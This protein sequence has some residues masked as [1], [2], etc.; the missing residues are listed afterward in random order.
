MKFPRLD[1]DDFPPSTWVQT[2]TGKV[3][4]VIKF[5]GLQSKRDDFERCVV[6]F[7]GNARDTVV[8]QP[9]LLAKLD[10]H[11]ACAS[12]DLKIIT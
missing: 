9:H 12:D 3:G 7:G 5:R 4:V 8:L 6:W 11:P 1:I 2:P 10:K